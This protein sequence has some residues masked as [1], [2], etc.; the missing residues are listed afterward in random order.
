[1]IPLFSIVALKL[2]FAINNKKLHLGKGEKRGKERE[3]AIAIDGEVGVTVETLDNSSAGSWS[4][5]LLEA[6]ENHFWSKQVR[7]REGN[8]KLKDG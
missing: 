1:M 3:V 6:E 4:L 7:N 8:G 5:L 2:L